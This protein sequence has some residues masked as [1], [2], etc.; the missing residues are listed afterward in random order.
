MFS[1]LQYSF[2]YYKG[3]SVGIAPD[4]RIS[5]FSCRRTQ[6]FI[7]QCRRL[8]IAFF[9]EP[10]IYKKCMS[11]FEDQL[12]YTA[13]KRSKNQKVSLTFFQTYAYFHQSDSNK[14]LISKCSFS[15]H[16]QYVLAHFVIQQF[17]PFIFL[18]VKLFLC[19]CNG[20]LG[21]RGKKRN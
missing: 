16:F 1:A 6:I 17:L 11:K 7:K 13:E 15:I 12:Y 4:H 21:Q 19:L 9:P 14:V 20:V 5:K 10:Q 3:K 2:V 8:Q 18:F